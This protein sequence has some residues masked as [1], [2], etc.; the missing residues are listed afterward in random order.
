MLLSSD[1]INNPLKCFLFSIISSKFNFKKKISSKSW[2]SYKIQRKTPWPYSQSNFLISWK[3]KNREK[4]VPPFHWYWASKTLQFKRLRIQYSAIPKIHNGTKYTHP[5]EENRI[6]QAADPNLK[7]IVSMEKRSR[8]TGHRIL[9]I[10]YCLMHK[11]API[12]EFKTLLFVNHYHQCD[13]IR[14]LFVTILQ[15][16]LYT[17]PETSN[18]QNKFKMNIFSSS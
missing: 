16:L 18:R 13:Y 7:L 5:K 4:D 8:A 3:L 11:L 14:L 15:F 12:I 9:N 6:P 10:N 17:E 1:A 2:T